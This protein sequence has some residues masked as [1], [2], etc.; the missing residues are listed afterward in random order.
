MPVI[1]Y[2]EIAV[3]NVINNLLQT[4]SEAKNFCDCE[5]CRSRALAKALNELSPEYVASDAEFM[6]AKAKY[7]R[8]AEY[9]TLIAI[10]MDSIRKVLSEK[11]HNMPPLTLHRQ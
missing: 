9:A 11:N 6:A 7:Q 2:T 4:F 1:N 10:V 3:K 5:I 8:P